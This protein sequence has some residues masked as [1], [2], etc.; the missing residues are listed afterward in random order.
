MNITRRNAL[1]GGAALG[2]VAAAAA[3]VPTTGKAAT[4]AD[5]AIAAVNEWYAAEAALAKEDARIEALRKR[6]PEDVRD[7]CGVP[8][9]TRRCPDGVMR[10]Y[11]A[12]TEFMIN[13][14]YVRLQA[15]TITPK[16]KAGLEKGRD[17]AIA[18]L[19]R[20]RA[21]EKAAYRAVGM[22]FAAR[23]EDE[24]LESWWRR[25]SDA[26][27]V[28]LSTPAV[29]IEGVHAKMRVAAILCRTVNCD[30]SGR[31]MEEDERQL[32]LDQRIFLV[33]C[34]DLERVTGGAS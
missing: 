32:D 30:P 13:E 19:R 17:G 22:P 28:I 1:R 7:W 31:F 24:Y 18:E 34:R 16:A 5:P 33:A 27:Q 20:M 12:R 14:Q 15:L 9:G 6:L 29:T 8:F 11:F 23:D 3:V 10:P 2:A 21:R 25:S 4:P 26:E